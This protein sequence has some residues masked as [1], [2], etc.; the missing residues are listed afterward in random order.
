MSTRRVY[1]DNAA[2][3]PVRPEVREAMMPFLTDAA[4]GNPSSAHA[5]G[6]AARDGVERA[7]R[8]VAAALGCAPPEVVFTSGGTEADNLAV[9]GAALAS[10][11]RGGPF[12]VAV[13]AVEHPAVLAAADAV[14]GLGGDRVVLPV[15]ALGQIRRADVERELERGLAVVSAMWVNNEVGTVQDVTYLSERARETGTAFHTDAVQA[16]GKLPCNVTTLGCTLLSLSGHKIGAPKGVG[17]LVVRN[18][19]TIEALQ[20][21]G[22][23]QFG[24][25]PGTEN[26]AGIA[27]LGEAVHLAVEE[28]DA[29]RTHLTALRDTFETAVLEAVP[30][31]QVV[32][33]DAERAPHV[34]NVI[35]PNIDADAALMHLDLAGV[36]CS[37]GSACKTGTVEPSK[38][39]LALGVPADLA[40]CS[41]R[42]SWY[43]QTT[44]QDIEYALSVLPD[45]V[46]KVRKERVG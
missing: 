23:Q 35:F 2:T 14:R 36:A 11:N 8:Q 27:A 21:G 12:R 33:A 5:F 31:A 22:G 26:T 25:R 46:E 17:A 13:S 28:L 32:G 4:F 45:I 30:D 15:D 39:L 1:L 18:P 20:H 38:V 42:F 37:T 16:V 29:T 40:R 43:K 44:T 24:L 19:D 9:I 41:L 3:T 7:R 10:R 6:R 34:S